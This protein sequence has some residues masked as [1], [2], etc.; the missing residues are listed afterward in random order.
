MTSTFMEKLTTS[1]FIGPFA[2]VLALLVLVVSEMGHLELRRINAE[3]EAS[4]QTQLFV[5]RLRRSLLLMESSIR[6]YLVTGRS[7]YLMPHRQQIPIFE[8]TL[9]SAQL[10]SLTDI[11]SK[12]I[13]VELVEMAKRKQADLQEMVALFQAGDRIGAMVSLQ[14]DVGL[15]MM[16]QIS[17]M[18][19]QV[20]RLESAKF[21]A[22]G[23]VRAS[24][25]WVSRLLI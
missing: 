12:A 9:E 14:T 3:R 4:V 5:G 18:V 11:P 2:I 6:G 15:K 25:A 17:D 8:S 24:S 7:E 20:I 13:L 22:A 23:E 16:T 21:S 1:R 10:L 19:D